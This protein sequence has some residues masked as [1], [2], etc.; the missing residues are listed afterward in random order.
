MALLPAHAMPCLTTSQTSFG[1]VLGTEVTDKTFLK[2]ATFGRISALE[3]CYTDDLVQ[4][5][6]LIYSENSITTP[7]SLLGT[8][9]LTCDKTTL[10]IG[11]YL[12]RLT[13]TGASELQSISLVTSK[14]QTVTYG[15]ALEESA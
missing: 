10:E 13:V 9:T 3:V 1:L 14:K 6:Q 2:D 5:I 8:S 4:S 11:E 15:I 7:L 12:K